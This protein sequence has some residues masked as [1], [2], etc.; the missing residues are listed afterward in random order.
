MLK[1]M[2]NATEDAVYNI[3]DYCLQYNID[4][5]IRLDGVVYGATNKSH[6]GS[7]ENLVEDLKKKPN[8]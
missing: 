1:K 8:K 2:V 5:K 3:R 7:F 4:A 6:K